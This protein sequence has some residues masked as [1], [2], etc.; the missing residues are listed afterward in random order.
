METKPGSHWTLGGESLL[1]ESWSFKAHPQTTS[2]PHTNTH[3][4]SEPL[5][6]PRAEAAA[7]PSLPPDL[8]Q[9]NPSQPS[10]RHH[11]H[12]LINDPCVPRH[13][14]DV[15]TGSVLSRDCCH[16]RQNCPPSSFEQ[17]PASLSQ[18]APAVVWLSVE[19]N[20]FFFV[21]VGFCLAQQAN[22]SHALPTQTSTEE[23]AGLILE[24]P[25]PATPDRDSL[26]PE[27]S[28]CREIRSTH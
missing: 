12:D 22:P 24:Q 19:N 7:F 28:S 9:T 8:N 11:C 18:P 5:P 16:E 3:R 10:C 26:T 20:F 27:P 14:S 13:P 2:E 17:I 25:H 21:G 23:Q 6:V 4:P 15:I 1:L